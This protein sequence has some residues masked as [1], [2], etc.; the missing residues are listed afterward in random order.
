MLIKNAIYP[1]DLTGTH[2]QFIRPFL[3]KAKPGGR[4]R[5]T[6]LRKVVS[7]IFF[8]S[9]TGSAWRY[10]PK[11]FPPW[12]TVYAYFSHWLKCGVWQKLHDALVK[13]WR[14]H[15]GKKATPSF[16]IVDSQAIKALRGEERGYDGFK[17]IRGR[18]RQI[19]VDTLG[20]LHAVKIHAANRSD[21]QAGCQI[22]TACSKELLKRLEGIFVDLGYR[23]TFVTETE[24]LLGFRPT[25]S[26]P[27][28]NLGQGIPKTTREWKKSQRLRDGIGR[29]WIVERTFAW[30]GYFR[31]LT[32]DYETNVK[33]SEA[34]IYVAM[35]RLVLHRLVNAA[36]LK[37]QATL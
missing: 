5:T 33:S 26:N 19:L 28:P 7:A 23:G 6:N 16:G 24:K 34:M 36:Q 14:R 29:R 12:P 13:S 30:F 17:K 20:L 22:F 10:L 37:A 11:D 18:K 21:T 15:E 2:W 32:R 3:P 1:S 9:R 4:P 27:D 25:T 35:V 8:V 31:R